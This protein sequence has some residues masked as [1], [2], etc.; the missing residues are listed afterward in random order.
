MTGAVVVTART[1]P[2]DDP[3]AGEKD[4]EP[5]AGRAQLEAVAAARAPVVSRVAETA[6]SAEA[7]LVKRPA[8]LPVSVAASTLDP[9]LSDAMVAIAPAMGA[10]QPVP[11]RSR[12]SRW[13]TTM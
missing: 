10:E 1:D 9:V 5:P 3:A 12:R 6:T 11:Q 13:S 2:M 4:A 8:T 7:G